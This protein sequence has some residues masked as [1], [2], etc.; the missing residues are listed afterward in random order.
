[1]LIGATSANPSDHCIMNNQMR[2]ANCV[3]VQLSYYCLQKKHPLVFNYFIVY[4]HNPCYP[5]TRKPPD[6]WFVWVF[7]SLK[8]EC[9]LSLLVYLLSI[10]STHDSSLSLSSSCVLCFVNYENHMVITKPSCANQKT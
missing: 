6:F 2:L 7:F 5:I 3:Q 9:S 1:M 4:N 10:C 8:N